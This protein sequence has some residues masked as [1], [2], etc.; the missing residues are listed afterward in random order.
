VKEASIEAASLAC[1]PNY[2]AENTIAE[3]GA[4]GVPHK[5]ESIEQN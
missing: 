4:E 1:P 3:S 2:G 5:L